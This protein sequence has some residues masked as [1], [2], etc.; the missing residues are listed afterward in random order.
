MKDVALYVLLVLFGWLSYL[1]LKPFLGYIVFALLFAFLFYPV[2]DVLNKGLWSWLSASIVLVIVLLCIIIPSVYLAG[3]LVQQ[4]T[5]AYQTVQASGISIFDET[6]VAEG[7]K[8]WTG[9]DL[10]DQVIEIFKRSREMLKQAIPGI[11]T[12][13]GSFL[14]GLFLFFFVL[15]FA[16]VDGSVWFEY[17]MKALPIKNQNKASVADKLKKQTKALLYGQI[18]TSV[19]IGAFIGYLFWLFSVPNAVFWGFVA[20]ILG[21]IP[22]VGAFLVYIPAGVFLIWQGMWF[23]GIALMI[24]SMAFHFIVDN[25]LRPKILSQASEIHPVIVILGALGGIALTGVVGFFVGPLILSFFVT[26][27]DIESA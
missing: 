11:I 14:M 26:L 7:I 23:N 18:L 25:I 20:I 8:S 5:A 10:H 13:T 27:L 15:Y 17:T 16:L 9:I 19:I 21:I 24:L 12:S 2:Y 1:I 3:T 4:T 6:S 22:A